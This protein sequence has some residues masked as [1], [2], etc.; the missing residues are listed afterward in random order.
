[1]VLFDDVMVLRT[2]TEPTGDVRLTIIYPQSA[3]CHCRFYC[4]RCANHISLSEV[5]DK[6]EYIPVVGVT[7]APFVDFSV[8]EIFDIAKVGFRFLE[9]LSYLTAVA[10]AELRR[11]LSNMSLIF[12]R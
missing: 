4:S 8:E 6:V 9:S 2:I 3:G 5:I 11:H 12:I 1:M 10:A 7:K